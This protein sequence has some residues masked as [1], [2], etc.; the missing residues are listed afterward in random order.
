MPEN[1]LLP[2]RLSAARFTGR[3]T[4][5]H[6]RRR[7]AWSGRT[8]APS[9]SRGRE[10]LCEGRDRAR[11]ACPHR[12]PRH[13][14]GVAC[15]IR[16]SRQF[17]AKV[18]PPRPLGRLS[19]RRKVGTGGGEWGKSGEVPKPDPGRIVDPADAFRTSR[20]ARIAGR[21]LRI[22]QE[23][24]EGLRDNGW[25]A[26][27]TSHLLKVDTGGRDEAAPGEL[28]DRRPVVDDVVRACSPP[29]L[30]RSLGGE[31]GRSTRDLRVGVG[32]SGDVGSDR[33]L[34]PAG[35]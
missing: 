32:V 19:A 5:P 9:R 25:P 7:P 35:E 18:D 31:T 14:S 17:C 34:A 3:V 24:T 28:P 21:G 11:S 30:G 4:R 12:L 22:V 13:R 6:P 27:P 10:P 33:E 20:R 8:P 2:G 29:E 16:W 26:T 23:G 1:L 15:R